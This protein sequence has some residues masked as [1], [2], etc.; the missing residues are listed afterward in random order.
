MSSKTNYN[1]KVPLLVQTRL[2][3]FKYFASPRQF[4][5]KAQKKTIFPGANRGKIC[6]LLLCTINFS[7]KKER[8][9]KEQLIFHFWHR[10][11]PKST[12]LQMH[13]A[14]L[15]ENEIILVSE[16]NDIW[17]KPMLRPNLTIHEPL[18]YQQEVMNFALPLHENKIKE[19]MKAWNLERTKKYY[20][21]GRTVELD[22]PFT[23]LQSLLSVV[24]FTC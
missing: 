19:N 2:R 1:K 22:A 6:V 21:I 23:L 3:R 14:K 5:M 4:V 8:I 12:S 16:T 15:K 9:K 11:P 18:V 20:E 10:K 17:C 7:E 13:W 24:W